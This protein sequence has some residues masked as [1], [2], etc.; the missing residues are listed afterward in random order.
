MTARETEL[1]AIIKQ[2]RSALEDAPHTSIFQNAIYDAWYRGQRRKAL[3]SSDP[4]R[5]VRH[6]QR[7]VGVGR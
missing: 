3:E 1:A 2:Q 4:D 5:W 7:K 6:D